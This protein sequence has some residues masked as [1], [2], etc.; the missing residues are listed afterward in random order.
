MKPRGRIGLVLSTVPAYSETFFR[1][2]ISVLQMEGFEVILFAGGGRE[3]SGGMGRIVMGYDSEK[4]GLKKLLPLAMACLKLLAS[5]LSAIRLFRMNQG[6]GYG[7]NENISSLLM[8]AHILGH[9]VDWLHFGF[10]SNALMLENVAKVV[11]ARMAVSIRGYDI[12]I[13]PLKNPGC[14]RRVWLRT[15]KLHYIS[16]A[17]HG[18]ALADGLPASVPSMKIQPAVDLSAMDRLPAPMPVT[19]GGL[20]FMTIGRLTWKKGYGHMLY[21]LSKLKS[22]GVRFTYQI[23]G[24]G[25]AYEELLYLRNMLG[26]SDEVVLEGRKSHAD[27]LALLNQCDVYLQYSIQEGFCNAVVEAQMLG[28]PC[29]VSDAEGLPE[30]VIH[31]RTGWVVPRNEPLL[32]MEAIR[33][34]LSMP[35]EER[36]AVCRSA[37]VRIR[38]EYSLEAQGRKF[39]KFYSE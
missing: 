30:N 5:P 22:E 7:R 16:D 23:V 3:Q 35:S 32:L 26:L 25:E 14:Y 28:K 11:G 17:L 18:L 38:D 29:I 39:I 4:K 24:Q 8:S 10:A 37:A 2:K 34:V 21:A 36:E 15:D 31:G 13:L 6:D 33:K 12:S 27:A 1:N 20:R 9:R 19:D